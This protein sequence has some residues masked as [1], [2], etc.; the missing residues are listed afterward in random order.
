MADHYG[1]VPGRVYPRPAR[2]P[3]VLEAGDG[4]P[5]AVGI[6][7]QA[8]AV[9]AQRAVDHA[10]VRQHRIG[11]GAG[12][13]GKH[14]IG[15]QRLGRGCAEEGARLDA[16]PAGIE[17]GAH[18]LAAQRLALVCDGGAAGGLPLAG[19]PVVA[20]AAGS[21]DHQAMV[22]VDDG[23]A[24]R[25]GQH[26]KQK[27]EAATARHRGLPG[28]AGPAYIYHCQGARF[29][30]GR[31]CGS[32]RPAFPVRWLAGPSGAR[33]RGRHRGRPVWRQP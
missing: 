4:N 8:Q 27:R 25:G 5:V 3:G 22:V 19:V 12:E 30:E 20:A 2:L 1:F 6:G 29:T 9:D 17:Q 28:V 16:L 24:R 7:G 13:V 33:A 15:F 31:A 26:A 10:Q 21:F 14:G 18:I 11:A 23:R 32:G